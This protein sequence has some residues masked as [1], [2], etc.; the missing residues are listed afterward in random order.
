MTTIQFAFTGFGNIAKTHMTALRAMPIIKPLPLL[1]V[2]DT[3]VTR[4][5][6]RHRSQAE[7]IGFRRVTDSVQEAVADDHVHVLDICTPNSR[8]YEDVM[9]AL[10]Q[11]KGIYC[12]KPITDT[13]ENSAR[14][15][16]ETKQVPGLAEQLAFTFRY[17]PA[18]M[19]IRSI[20]SEGIVG[21]IL[22]CSISYR[23]SGYLD[24]QRPMSWRLQGGLSGGGATSDLAVHALDMIRHWFGDYKQVTGQAR[25][26]VQS[27]PES[28]GS[29]IHVPSEVDDW[30]MMQY[31]TESGVSGT[32]E[33]SRIALGSEA[34]EIRI[35]GTHGSITADLERDQMPTV[36]LVRGSVPVLPVPNSLELLPGDKATMGIAVDTH[37]AALY[38][39]IQR[40][41]GEDRY[42][43]L[44]PH[45]ADGLHV[46][47]WIDRVLRSSAEEQ[48]R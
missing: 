44:A 35:V 28:A 16:E 13:Y 9:A 26:H 25:A 39:Y 31:T 38:H 45:L 22:Q 30:A 42:P 10:P 15:V 32:V 20:L 41:A 37:F 29:T 12:E 8:H 11:G 4:Q 3:L 14:L 46:E 5:P 17:H 23:R 33:V 48:T 24:P 34:F 7:A 43:E 27:R 18:V 47:Y 19:R 36:H 6:D 21:D 1:P 2:L 40:Y